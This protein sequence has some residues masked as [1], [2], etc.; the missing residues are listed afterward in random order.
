MAGANNVRF[1]PIRKDLHST[2][3]AGTDKYPKTINAK[4]NYLLLKY[5]GQ[6]SEDQHVP[7]KGTGGVME[8][9]SAQEE[10]EVRMLDV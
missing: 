4:L 10:I 9:V 3:I 2:Y 1:G 7:D 6:L 8:T 5:D